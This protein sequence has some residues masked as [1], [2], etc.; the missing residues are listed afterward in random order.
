MSDNPEQNSNTEGKPPEPPEE[1]KKPASEPPSAGASKESAPQPPPV[2]PP[3]SPP[4]P[5]PP[6]TQ[7]GQAYVSPN[8]TIMMILAYLGILALIPLL[9]EKDDGEV[10]WHAKHG[11]VLTAFWIVVSVVLTLLTSIPG[12][13]CL[14]GFISVLLPLLILA[15]HIFLMIKAVNGER[16]KFPVISDFADKWQ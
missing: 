9:V 13:G 3:K 7:T 2:E 10:Q 5:P 14:I 16:F 11:L 1:P 8:R 15:I 4:G 12:I 6:Q